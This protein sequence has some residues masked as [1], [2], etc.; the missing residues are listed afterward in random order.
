MTYYCE[1]CLEEVSMDEK[2][3]SELLYSYYVICRKC[4]EELKKKGKNE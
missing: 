3:E 1:N 4:Q 2:E